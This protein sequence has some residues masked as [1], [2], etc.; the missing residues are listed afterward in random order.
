MIP[1]MIANPSSGIREFPLLLRGVACVL[2]GVTLFSGLDLV[3][4]AGG[5]VAVRGPAGAGKSALLR[6]LAGVISPAA[7]EIVWADGRT[8]RQVP[9]RALSVG[10]EDALK[11]ALTVAENLGFWSAFLDLRAWPRGGDPFGT[12]ILADVPVAALSAGQR[13]CVAL[14]RLALAETGL[15]LLD[16]PGAGL[17]GTARHRLA[18]LVARH[19]ARGGAVAFS[20]DL[21]IPGAREI[22]LGEGAA[23]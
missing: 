23:S 1:A 5:A 13:R 21:A 9:E 4:E 17:D 8:P 16:D 2:G 18:D 6:L 7:G 15:W 22:A 12:W 19:R 14:T 11:P 20:G 10:R 3:I